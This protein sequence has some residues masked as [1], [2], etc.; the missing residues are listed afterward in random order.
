[1]GTRCFWDSETDSYASETYFN[2]SGPRQLQHSVPPQ[3]IVLPQ[4]QENIFCVATVYGIY[5][6]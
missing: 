2:V 1:M 5:C 3:T 6:Y 4:I